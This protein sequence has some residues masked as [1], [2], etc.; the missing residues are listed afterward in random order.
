MDLQKNKTVTAPTKFDEWKLIH[1][2]RASV[3][4]QLIPQRIEKLVD[5]ALRDFRNYVHPRKEIRSQH[6]CGKNEASSAVAALGMVID[7]LGSRC[8]IRSV[9][10]GVSRNCE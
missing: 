5:T 7:S 3:Q 6:T 4:I 8:A 10:G 2:I 1:L 9:Q